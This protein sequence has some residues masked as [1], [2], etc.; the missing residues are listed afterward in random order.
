M[1]IKENLGKQSGCIGKA[2]LYV[3]TQIKLVSLN[4]KYIVYHVVC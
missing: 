3:E 4:Y 1:K 2:V